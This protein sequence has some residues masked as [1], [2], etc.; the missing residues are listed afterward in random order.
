MQRMLTY[1]TG[2]TQVEV[3][4]GYWELQTKHVMADLLNSQYKPHWG[5]DKP[6]EERGNGDGCKLGAYVLP[7]VLSTDSLSL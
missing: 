6:K 7:R 4:Y 5:Y 1:C 2:N 3:S